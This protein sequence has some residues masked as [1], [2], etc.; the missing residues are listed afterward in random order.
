MR[1]I[2]YFFLLVSAPVLADQDADFLAAND[3]FR[4]GDTA[5]L[6]RFAQRLKNTPLEVYVNYYQLR[7]NLDKADAGALKKFLSQP[8]DTP[9]IDQLRGEWL[10]VLGS[11][12]QWDL[13]DA[14]YALLLEED[15][16]LAC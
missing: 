1:F 6:Q 15:T 2:L 7:I 11:K 13:F 12:R 5:K 10:R 4:A 3:A 14:D 16:E 8:E 9:M